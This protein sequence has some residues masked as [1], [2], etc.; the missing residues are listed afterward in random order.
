MMIGLPVRPG[1]PT[2]SIGF[3]G[4]HRLFNPIRNHITIPL[5]GHYTLD[6]VEPDSSRVPDFLFFSVYEFPHR[7][8][9]YDTCVKIFTC[10]ENI[11]PPWHECEYAMTGDHID[12]DSRHLRTPIYVRYLYYSDETVGRS[13]VRPTSH[14][15][16]AILR[17]KTRFCNFVYSNG[18]ARE[19]LRF[20]DLLSK[21]KKVESGGGVRNNLGYR[22]A[23][24]LCFLE[25]YKFTIAFENSSYPG[26]ISEKLVEP[27]LANSI[28]IYWGCPRVGEDFNQASIVNANGRR[29]EDVVSEVVRLDLND[30]EYIAKLKESPFRNNQPNSYCAPEHMVDFMK[31]IF[32]SRSPKARQTD[33]RRLNERPEQQEQNTRQQVTR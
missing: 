11:R 3:V 29:M 17:S 30:S 6:V 13:L 22:V 31:K 5:M 33:A 2:V 4:F 21:Y 25:S 27:M 23:D 32:D 20:L 19:R 1:E 7:N 15:A 12:G 8:P 16:E 18:H 24:K 9:K 14:N 28:P 10:E 26:Y